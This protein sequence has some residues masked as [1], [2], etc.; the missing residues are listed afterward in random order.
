MIRVLQILPRVPPAVCGIGDYAWGI[1]RKL[2]NEHGIHSSF[3]AAG[4]TWTQPV[5]ETEFPVFRLPE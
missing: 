1:A 5:G 3:L 4:T 2:R